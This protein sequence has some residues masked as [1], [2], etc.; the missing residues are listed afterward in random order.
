MNRR[1]FLIT[2]AAFSAAALLRSS[3][4]AGSV[5]DMNS[6][7][8]PQQLAP[9]IEE[10]TKEF[11]LFIDIYQQEI[12]PDVKFH[13]LALNNQVPDPEIRVNRGDKV[14]VIF[15]NKTNLS[16][17]IHW[18]ACAVAHGRVPYVTQMPVSLPLGNRIAY[19]GRDVW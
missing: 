2:G 6:K 11:Q 7:R 3:L 18:H 8:F 5:K 1:Q 4:L 16:H 17:T 12:V 13:T 19:T 15:E 9:R 14:R 10:D